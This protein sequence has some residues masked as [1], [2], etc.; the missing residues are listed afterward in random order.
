M[1][2]EDAA[3]LVGV[4]A[5]AAVVA[6]LVAPL[7]LIPDP[8]T[9]LGV[10]YAFGPAGATV[11]G[12]LAPLAVVVFLAGRR[13]RTDPATAAGLTLVL[14]VGMFVLAALWAF[15]VDVEVVFSFSAAWMGSHRWVVLGLT[16]LVP[17]SAAVY[18][19]A[20]L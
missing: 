17:A 9:E 10:Y 6:A 7:V 18:A 19:R 3:P 2:V 13:G 12:A 8:G 4:A 16:T 14:G 15:A 11:L 5:C 20:V 1:E